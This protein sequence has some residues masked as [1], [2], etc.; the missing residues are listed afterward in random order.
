MEQLDYLDHLR[1]SS[2]RLVEAADGHLGAPVPGCPKWDVADLAYHVGR[3]DDFWVAMAR[4]G[5]PEGYERPT[6]P[7]D[8]EVLAWFAERADTLADVLA[9]T[10]PAQPAWS[11]WGLR[12]VAFVRRRIAHETAVHAWDAGDASGSRQPIDAALAIDGIDEHFEIFSPLTAGT[13]VPPVTTVH[14]HATDA[15][16]EWLLS[17][18]GGVL[19]V[20]RSH[21]KGDVAVRGSASDLLL[22]LW[23]RIGADADD[24]QVFGEPQALT[25]L[26]GTSG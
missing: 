23:D 8:D 2:S 7:P 9:A 19:S 20:E 15:D 6:R 16:G 3:V 12:D 13:P 17:V 24:L 5:D 18:G 4:G 25:A 10:D 26:R 11:F 1:R 22:L 14:L 21:G